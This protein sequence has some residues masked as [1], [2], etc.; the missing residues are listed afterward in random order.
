MRMRWQQQVASVEAPPDSVT[1]LS[2]S[3]TE[4]L[5]KNSKIKLERTITDLLCATRNTA[6]TKER[7]LVGGEDIIDTVSANDNHHRPYGEFDTSKLRESV[8]KLVRV[9]LLLWWGR[10]K[11]RN[12]VCSTLRVRLWRRGSCLAVVSYYSKPLSTRY[13]LP[14]RNPTSPSP[15]PTSINTAYPSSCEP[16][17]PCSRDAPSR[18]RGVR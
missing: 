8:A 13:Q 5:S 15:H 6:V 7:N 1:S 16:L 17:P 9:L 3:A 4:H 12:T 18:G 11:T 10:R 2:S 14:Y